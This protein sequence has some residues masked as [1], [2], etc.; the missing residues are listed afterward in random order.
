MAEFPH[1]MISALLSQARAPG[2]RGGWDCP[3]L[4]AQLLA[5][6][7]GAQRIL[8]AGELG[9]MEVGL[10]RGILDRKSVV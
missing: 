7:S 3:L 9:E 4:A 8:R 1:E 10:G 6:V 2:G 5:Q